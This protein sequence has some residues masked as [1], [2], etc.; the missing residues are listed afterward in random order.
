MAKLRRESQKLQ[1]AVQAQEVE[2]VKM[3]VF[4]GHNSKT[5][6]K[7]QW[8]DKLRY[9]HDLSR[10][11]EALIKIRHRLRL[12]AIQQQPPITPAEAQVQLDAFRERWAPM[13]LKIFAR[14][15]P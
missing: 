5:D 9:H 11:E 12:N 14:P 10:Q 2:F 8:Y 6:P 7:Y 13:I 3:K 4:G 1:A 15:R